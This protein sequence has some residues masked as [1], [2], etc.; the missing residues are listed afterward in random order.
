MKKHEVSLCCESDGKCFNQ[1]ENVFFHCLSFLCF[2]SC[3]CFLL[4]HLFFHLSEWLFCVLVTILNVT[5]LS[6]AWCWDEDLV[7][8]LLGHEKTCFSVVIPGPSSSQ[9]KFAPL[10]WASGWA[11]R[12]GLRHQY[13][14]TSGLCLPTIALCRPLHLGPQPMLLPVDLP[15]WKP[16]SVR[17]P[18]PVSWNANQRFFDLDW[19]HQILF[20]HYLI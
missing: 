2:Q 14:L 15:W 6:R 5:P 19:G 11:L 16:S 13:G 7:M 4:R 9:F 8:L 10:C 1:T 17:W 3:F 20:F 12:W 18:P